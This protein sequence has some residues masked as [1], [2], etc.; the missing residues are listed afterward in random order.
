M[1]S[2]F[3]FLSNNGKKFSVCKSAQVYHKHYLL[4]ICFGFCLRY[5]FLGVL[6]PDV[7]AS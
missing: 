5:P 2:F 4:G 3:F 7:L 6:T 1:F